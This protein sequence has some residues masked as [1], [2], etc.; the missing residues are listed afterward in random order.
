M[1][2]QSICCVHVAKQSLAMLSTAP[3]LSKKARHELVIALGYRAQP[4]KECDFPHVE[5]II[6]HWPRKQTLD[7]YV[8]LVLKIVAYFSSL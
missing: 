8:Q 2:V 7:L 1:P 3:Q 4:D 5:A 6:D